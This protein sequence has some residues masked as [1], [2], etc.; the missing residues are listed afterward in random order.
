LTTGKGCE[1]CGERSPSGR[2]GGYSK[3][4]KGCSSSP[5]L[6]TMKVETIRSP[7][8]L[9][10]TR[11]TRR[12]NPEDGAHHSHRRENLKSYIRKGCS[13]SPIFITMKVKAIRPPET[14]VPTRATR[15]NIPED[16]AHHSHR[17]GNLRSST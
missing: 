2:G 11:A 16:G 14:L 15:R 6:I 8:T 17:R 3:L 1:V 10:S 13:S 9:V 4:R 5:I 7:E 12:N